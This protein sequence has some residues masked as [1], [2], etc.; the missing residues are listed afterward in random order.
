M[1]LGPLIGMGVAALCLQWPGTPECMPQWGGVI[2]H[3]SVK[4]LIAS[5][6]KG[7]LPNSVEL[8]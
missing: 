3:V 2:S 7:F 1:T 4:R 5:S 8:T 6:G